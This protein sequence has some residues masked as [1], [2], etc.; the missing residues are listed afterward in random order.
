MTNIAS[1]ER[2]DRGN[3]SKSTGAS[4]GGSFGNQ[5]GAPVTGGAPENGERGAGDVHPPEHANQGGKHEHTQPG[6]EQEQGKT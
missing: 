3:P 4:G 6:H 1:D 5:R 2:D